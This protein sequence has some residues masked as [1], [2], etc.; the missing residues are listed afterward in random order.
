MT[1]VSTII[2]AYNAAKFVREAVDSA[3]AQI[4]VENEVIVV[5]DGSTDETPQILAEYGSRIQVVRQVNQGQHAARNHGAR[6]ARGEWLAFLDADDIWLPEKLARQ[7]ACDEPQADLRFTHRENFGEIDRVTR[8][9]PLPSSGFFSDPF[10]SMFVLNPITTSSVLLR[11]SVFQNLGGFCEQLTIGCEDWDLWLRYAQ[12][13]KRFAFLPK[14]L[15]R[16][17]LHPQSTSK[18][19]GRMC[20]A[21]LEVMKR[22]LSTEKGRSLPGPVLRRVYANH[23]QAAGWDAAP[24]DRWQS[25]LWYCKSLRYA[26]TDVIAYKGIIKSLLG[27]T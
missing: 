1:T 18:S 23:W 24:V 25:I 9:P 21:R 15:L 26:P 16:Y 22:A 19:V 10:N 17:R 3:L 6:V 8:H 2:P 13:G 27:R 7:L 11:K 5:D 4:G 14:V 12:L 20:R